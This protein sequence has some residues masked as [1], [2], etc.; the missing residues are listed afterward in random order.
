MIEELTDKWLKEWREK[1][2]FVKKSYQDISKE[3]LKLDRR[4]SIDWDKNLKK[5]EEEQSRITK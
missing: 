5:Y 1:L 4:F 3:A 2:P